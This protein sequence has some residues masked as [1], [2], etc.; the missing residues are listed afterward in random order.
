MGVYHFQD[1]C[2]H[3]DTSVEIQFPCIWNNIFSRVMRYIFYWQVYWRLKCLTGVLESCKYF[4]KDL[5]LRYVSLFQELSPFEVYLEPSS[6]ELIE[7]L[8]ALFLQTHWHSFTIL[9]DDTVMSM[10]LQRKELVNILE[11]PPLHPTIMQL[12]SIK[13]PHALFR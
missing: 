1:S 8:R 2:L 4:I 10:M 11:E 12:P 6:R 13:Q 3:P 7:A 5:L 9:A